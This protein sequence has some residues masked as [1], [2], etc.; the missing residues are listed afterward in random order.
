METPKFSSDSQKP[1]GKGTSAPQNTNTGGG[2]R[3]NGPTK[4]RTESSAPANAQKLRG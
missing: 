2:S 1:G 4:Y 3:P